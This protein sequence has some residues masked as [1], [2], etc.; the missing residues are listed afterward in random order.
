MLSSSATPGEATASLYGGIWSSQNGYDI[1]TVTRTLTGTG[2]SANDLRIGDSIAWSS[3]KLILNAT[4]NIDID[5]TSGR[6]RDRAIVYC[7]M[8]RAQ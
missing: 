7:Y 3:N 4:N 1:N 2:S 8:D 5:S 6:I